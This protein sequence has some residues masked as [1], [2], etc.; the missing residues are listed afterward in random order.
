MS[1]YIPESR[2]KEDHSQVKIVGVDET[3]CAKFHKYVSLFVDLDDNKVLYACEG[4]DASV[5]SSFK[6]D[7]EAHDGASEN[8]EMF[9]S[10]MSPAF[11][12]GITEQFPGSSLT[13]DKFHVMKMVNEAVD[14]VRREEQHH[15]AQLKNTRYMWLK[16]PN[17]LSLAEKKS[18]DR[19]KI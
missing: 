6:K 1:Y 8:I 13:F 14:Q 10:D 5:I 9:C 3:S 16:N 19:S 18:L 17:D 2:S 15:N 4:K 12:S 7:L 11:I